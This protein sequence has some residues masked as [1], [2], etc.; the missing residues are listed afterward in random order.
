MLAYL[1]LVL[2]PDCAPLQSFLHVHHF[3]EQCLTGATIIDST[4]QEQIA[5]LQ[6]SLV[7]FDLQSFEQLL[8]GLG[9]CHNCSTGLIL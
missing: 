9:I 8:W 6:K 3:G 2:T 1:C 7:M 5:Y 4:Q